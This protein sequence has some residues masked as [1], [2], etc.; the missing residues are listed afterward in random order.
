M[1]KGFTAIKFHKVAKIKLRM[2]RF[3]T[4]GSAAPGDLITDGDGFDAWEFIVIDQEGNCLGTVDAF[5]AEGGLEIE[6]VQS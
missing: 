4:A 6:G 5:A 2:R 3:R 1:S